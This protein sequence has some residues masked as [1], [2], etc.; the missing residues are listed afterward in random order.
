[1]EPQD[2]SPEL[3]AERQRAADLAALLV[4]VGSSEARR[5]S[6]ER[7]VVLR[8]IRPGDLVTADLRVTRLNAHLDAYGRVARTW[9]G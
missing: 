4:G 6:E 3:A 5:L 2:L 8:L 1:M 7:G 9:L